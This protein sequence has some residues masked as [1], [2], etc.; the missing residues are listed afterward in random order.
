MSEAAITSAVAA[1]ASPASAT[2]PTAPAMWPLEAF[3]KHLASDDASVRLRALAMATMPDAPIDHCVPAIIHCAELSADDPCALQMAAVAMGSVTPTRATSELHGALA[4]LAAPAQ[5]A[6]VRIMATHAL[7]RLAVMPAAA[8]ESVCAL[9]VD[10]DANARQVALLALTPFATQCAAAIAAVVARTPPDRWH[11]ECLQALAR[12]T[13]TDSSA[14]RTVDAWLMRSLAG[15]LLLPTGIAAYAALAQMNPESGGVKALVRIAHE[16]EAS[17]AQAA[18]NAL[19]SL[20]EVAQSACGDLVAALL[21]C[22]DDAREALLCRTLV[23]LRL[24][25]REVPLAHCMRRIAEGSDRVAA[26]HCMLLCV[27]PKAS[28]SAAPLLRAR[29]EHPQTSEALRRALAQAH[30]TLTGSKLAPVAAVA[31]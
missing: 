15:Q 10:D 5:A 23:Q 9:L 2:P 24:R 17:A 19:G 22:R 27:H 1:D 7:F 28:A 25:E 4:K 6:P 12:S 20:G 13:G 18:L 30:E 11:T 8:V 3:T 26:A 21:E 14:K 16:G 29:H 31:G